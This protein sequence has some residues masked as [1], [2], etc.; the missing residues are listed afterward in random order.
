MAV[1]N[2]ETK[3]DAVLSKEKSNW[4]DKAKFRIEHK[5]WLQHSRQIALK[6]NTTLKD[7]GLTQKQLAERLEVSPQQVSKIMKGNENM[8]LETIA[9]IE[10]ALDVSLI[11]VTISETTLEYIQ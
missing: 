8:T 11:N 6:I 10:Y 2:I 9:K 3:L 1:K 5:S 7:K 4:R